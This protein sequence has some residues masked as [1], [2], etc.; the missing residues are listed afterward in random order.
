MD[1]CI[2]IVWYNNEYRDDSLL[3]E[4]IHILNLILFAV[5]NH[6]SLPLKC[7]GTKN[8]KVSLVSAICL[9]TLLNMTAL[10]KLNSCDW[11]VF[12]LQAVLT[13]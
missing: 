13:S 4:Q 8:G 10:G 1:Y 6:L 5:S 3:A 11:V 9:R 7:L 12:Q 2:I